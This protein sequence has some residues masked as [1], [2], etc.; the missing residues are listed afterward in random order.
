[1][2][3]ELFNLLAG[4]AANAIYLSILHARYENRL[5][6]IEDSLELFKGLPRSVSTKSSKTD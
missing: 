5:K 2:D 1:V 4:H 6:T 3:Y